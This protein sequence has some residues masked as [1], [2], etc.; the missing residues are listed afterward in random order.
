MTGRLLQSTVARVCRRAELHAHFASPARYIS[1]VSTHS[2]LLVP[3]AS[4]SSRVRT[5]PTYSAARERLHPSRGFTSTPVAAGALASRPT[6]QLCNV[7]VVPKADELE[8][9]EV[10]VEPIPQSE[11]KIM[12]TDSAA[13]VSA[14]L[15]PPA[16]TALIVKLC[17]SNSVR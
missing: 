5:T 12:L 4:G 16:R 11:A 17:C 14:L 15:C 13:E 6:A 7:T 10:D 8:D 2:S 3:H 9:L 1:G